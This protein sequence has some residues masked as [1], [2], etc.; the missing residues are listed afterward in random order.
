MFNRVYGE[1]EH[2]LL[3]ERHEYGAAAPLVGL[4]APVAVDL[5][6][7]IVVR[8]SAV[9]ELAAYWP[10]ARGLLPSGFGD[11]PERMCVLELTCVFPA[12][13]EEAPDA[14]GEF[15]DAVTALRLATAAPVAAGPI[16][17]ERLDWRPYGIRPVLPIAAT[18]PGGEP[19][20]LDEFRG[21]LAH[22][23]LE[24]LPACDADPELGEAV[25]RWE[26][27][28]FADEPFRSELLRESLAALLGGDDGLWAAAARAAVLVGDRGQDRGELF[29]VAA[30][31]H[32]RR[33]GRRRRVGRRPACPRRGVD[34]RRPSRPAGAA[35]RV[36]AGALA[37]AGELLRRPRRR[38]S[39][40][41][42]H[43]ELFEDRRRGGFLSGAA[44][45][46]RLLEDTAECL[47]ALGGLAERRLRGLEL[48]PSLGDRGTGG[49]RREPVPFGGGYEI[50]QETLGQSEVTARAGNA[51]R[52]GEVLRPE[53]RAAASQEAVLIDVGQG[54]AAVSLRLLDEGGHNEG[55][56]EYLRFFHRPR[57][58]EDVCSEH[59]SFV[60]GTA[61][62]EDERGV[63][64]RHR[65]R[66]SGPVL[67]LDLPYL[68][69]DAEELVPLSE[70]VQHP[71]RLG[72][73][74]RRLPAYFG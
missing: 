56:R 3:G 24:R 53:I 38:L 8:M 50:V 20:R 74:P 19:S 28:L 26:L 7:D 32:R 66:L 35:R 25:D 21:R 54:G 69:G 46:E 59:R 62:N 12:S 73:G 44:K 6:R 43:A 41:Q 64:L 58:G 63:C 68:F 5:G 1:I 42:R 48:F 18:E 4:S 51:H 15:A 22:D 9:G 60:D 2:S 52:V 13:Q 47:P 17:F 30:R 36:A 16:L 71:A 29:A 23:L 33:T 49:K 14:P 57:A 31:R 61:T 55:R 39:R 37:A 34:A 70:I 67:G 27:S 45:G 11:E 10:E 65:P 72:L 40:R